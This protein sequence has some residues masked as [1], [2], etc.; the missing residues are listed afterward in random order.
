MEP[1]AYN[2]EVLRRKSQE[3]GIKVG[4]E[5]HQF[6]VQNDTCQTQEWNGMIFTKC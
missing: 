2:C 4:F 6:F 3:K 5:K 1:V